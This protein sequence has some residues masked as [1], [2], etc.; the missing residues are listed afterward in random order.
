MKQAAIWIALSVLVLGGC[1]LSSDSGDDVVGGVDMAVLF[2]ETD[3][4]REECR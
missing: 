4:C 1:E 2:A 3:G